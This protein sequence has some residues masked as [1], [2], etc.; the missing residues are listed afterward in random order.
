[1][2]VGT[3]HLGEMF[4]ICIPRPLQQHTENMLF[5]VLFWVFS[6]DERLSF[7]R[8]ITRLADAVTLVTITMPHA[9]SFPRIQSEHL[10]VPGGHVKDV[11]LPHREISVCDR[12]IVMKVRRDAREVRR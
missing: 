8:R 2:W 6:P 10:E 11:P 9:H 3:D 4:E 7:I 1:M 5:V 12:A